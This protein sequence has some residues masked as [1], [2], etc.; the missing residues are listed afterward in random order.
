M[1]GELIINCPLDPRQLE[2]V[3]LN[4]ERIRLMDHASSV[5]FYVFPGDRPLL[6]VGRHAIRPTTPWEL[7]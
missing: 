3:V 4:G 2:F 5:E 1:S 6:K 7:P